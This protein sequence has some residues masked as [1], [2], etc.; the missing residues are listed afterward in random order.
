MQQEEIRLEH[1]KAHGVKLGDD[2]EDVWGWAT[3]AGKERVKRR[4][5][6]FIDLG[7]FDSDSDV[8]EIG[9]GTAIFT[10]KVYDAT[11][12]NITAIDISEA[13]LSQ[14][15]KK[16]ANVEFQIDNAMQMSF[17]KD[18]FDCVYGSSVLHHLD[19]AKAMK[20]VFRVTKPG[21]RIVFAEP[22]MLNPQ[23]MIERKVPFI[24]ER[25]GNSPDETAIVR[26]SMKK[27]LKEIGFEKVKVFP[28]DFLH[29][30]TPVP[31][32]GL[33]KGI[34]AIAERIPLLNE[35]AGSVVIYGEKPSG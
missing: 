20:E 23:I 2:A 3:P 21:G 13:L 31:L 17:D 4:A 8:L 35:I 27:M 5:G 7:G 9:C 19:M 30:A 6:Y 24:R 15:R 25:A 33:V 32:I 1:E 14:A 11:H 12:A 10:E 18:R 34:T 29:P 22:N 26:W 28:Y 16:L